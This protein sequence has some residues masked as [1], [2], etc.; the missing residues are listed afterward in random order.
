M[1]MTG[2]TFS[3]LLSFEM[4]SFLQNRLITSILEDSADVRLNVLLVLFCFKAHVAEQQATAALTFPS[5][6]ASPP[7]GDVP[8]R[9]IPG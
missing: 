2:L 7:G 4:I 6:S 5:P 9:E 3:P 1:F 8:P